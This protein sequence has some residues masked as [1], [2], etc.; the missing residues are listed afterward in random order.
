MHKEG[1]VGVGWA[2]V[3]SGREWRS[4]ENG[5]GEEKASKG[6]EKKGQQ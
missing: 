3:E 6:R 5:R 1:F 2:V 4:K